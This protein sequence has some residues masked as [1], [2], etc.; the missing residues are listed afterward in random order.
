MHILGRFA[1]QNQKNSPWHTSQQSQV[2]LLVLGC[3][4]SSFPGLG[5][6]FLQDFI[7]GGFVRSVP[8]EPL[9]ACTAKHHIQKHRRCSSAENWWSCVKERGEG[10]P[11]AAVHPNP[12]LETPVS[13][14]ITDWIL[15]ALTPG[16]DQRHLSITPTGN[17]CDPGSSYRVMF[18]AL[19]VQLCPGTLLE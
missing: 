5:C 7:T 4:W 10:H 12:K 13:S 14:Y 8:W 17:R 9:A 2:L 19:P 3:K 18:R 16:L 1:A 15:P 11:T 6:D